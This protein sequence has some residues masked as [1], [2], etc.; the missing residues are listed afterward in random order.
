MF[1][2]KAL[3]YTIGYALG[4][5]LIAIVIFA[6]VRGFRYYYYLFILE[7]ETIIIPVGGDEGYLRFEPQS[8][9]DIR[10]SNVDGSMKITVDEQGLEGNH[11]NSMN[12]GTITMK[13]QID[14]RSSSGTL[15]N[16]EHAFLNS[17]FSNKLANES[18]LRHKFKLPPTDLNPVNKNQNPNQLSSFGSLREQGVKN[19]SFSPADRS[20]R[21]NGV[22]H[23][24]VKENHRKRIIW[25]AIIL[26]M[27]I[28]ALA[29]YIYLG[30]R[31]R[32]RNYNFVADLAG[33]YFHKPDCDLMPSIDSGNTQIYR[34]YEETEES[35]LMSC[36]ICIDW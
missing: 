4:P 1:L 28:T 8:V 27:L 23:N 25:A 10:T 16:I 18:K 6:L 21:F 35:G 22:K 24:N 34:T 30:H 20:I 7:N 9:S 29:Y 13:F 14:N 32:Y 11:H 15:N 17:N 12:P 36:P 33:G 19:D 26:V 2:N 31:Y 5:I 3:L